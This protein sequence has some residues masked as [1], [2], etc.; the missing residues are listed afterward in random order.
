MTK[1]KI[2]NVRITDSEYASLKTLCDAEGATISQMIRQRV[3]EMAIASPVS[4]WD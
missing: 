1:D 2:V 3:Q 4:E